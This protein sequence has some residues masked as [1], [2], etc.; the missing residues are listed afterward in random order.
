MGPGLVPRAVSALDH[1]VSPA[2]DPR[3]C[4]VGPY[5]RGVEA[6][7]GEGR[8]G[9]RAQDRGRSAPP[10]SA[11]TPLLAVFCSGLRGRETEGRPAY[12]FAVASCVEPPKRSSKPLGSRRSGLSGE[13]TRGRAEGFEGEIVH[14]H[15]AFLL[16]YGP[17][18]GEPGGP[19]GSPFGGLGDEGLLAVS[20]YRAAGAALGWLGGQGCSHERIVL[21]TGSR[22]LGN[23]REE[24]FGVWRAS[25]RP[26]EGAA[27]KEVLATLLRFGDLSVEWGRPDC[28][29]QSEELVALA[30]EATQEISARARVAVLEEGRRERAMEVKLEKIGRGLYR[31][32]DRYVVDAILGLCGCRDFEIHNGRKRKKADLSLIVRCKHLI[33]AEEAEGQAYRRDYDP[34]ASRNASRPPLTRGA[35]S[36]GRVGGTRGGQKP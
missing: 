24:P 12:G 2:T 21:F 19:S 22:T 25:R 33:A 11:R 1:E 8:G 6:T 14:S 36:K 23:R 34:A 5:T 15:A 16:E 9:N 35:S 30:E 27:L 17:D 20:E 31:A 3:E 28:P 7:R 32:N 10:G 4:P 26:R 29:E 18:G 13:C